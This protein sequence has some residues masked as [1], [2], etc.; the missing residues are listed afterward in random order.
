[1][2]STP[3][4]QVEAIVWSTIT[5]ALSVALAYL[6]WRRYYA[7]KSQTWL[8]WFLGFVMFV[9]GSA[10]QVF[11]AFGIG[12]YLLSAIYV[13]VVA[14]LVYVLSMGSIRF[15][16]NPKLVR[17]YYIYG[18]LASI[19]LVASILAESFDVVV[20]YMPKKFPPLVTSTSS[21]LTIPATG[22]ILFL[23]ARS[24]LYKARRMKM[25]AIILS[26]VVL[27]FGG[28]LSAHGNYV[29]LY[30]SEIIGMALFL[31]GIY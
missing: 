23:A 20:D 5:L 29:A 21:A 10:C 14:E 22:V 4:I 6:A 26:I 30:L 27:G 13:F 16:D 18:A 2:D 15:I 1:M 9:I 12:G 19:A 24:L 7:T 17:Y 11:F 3:S 28:M 25:V 31:Y 8:Y